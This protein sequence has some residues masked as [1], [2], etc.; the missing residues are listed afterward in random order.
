MEKKVDLKLN[1]IVAGGYRIIE[2]LG[3]GS[4]GEIY[5]GRHVSSNEEVAIKFVRYLYN[6]DRSKVSPNIGS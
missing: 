1:K 6:L 3:S 2:K 5:K 4:F